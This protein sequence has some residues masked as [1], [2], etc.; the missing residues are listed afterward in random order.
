MIY[1]RGYVSNIGLTFILIHMLHKM[2]EQKYI[3]TNITTT[4]YIPIYKPEYTQE[5][6]FVRLFKYK[7]DK[8]VV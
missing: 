8:H 5:E 2:Q 7:I 3:P 4:T 6:Y 1:F